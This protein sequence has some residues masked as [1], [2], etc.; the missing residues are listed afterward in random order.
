MKLLYCPKCKDV[1]ALGCSERSCM[2]G[3][4]KGRYEKDGLHAVVS[5]DAEVLG[6]NNASLALALESAAL[7]GWSTSVEAWVILRSSDRVKWGNDEAL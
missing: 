7:G 1:V 2:C 5:G 3:H 6:I 4:V